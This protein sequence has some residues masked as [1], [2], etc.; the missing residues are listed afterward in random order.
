MA[1]P[2]QNLSVQAP[3][4]QGINSEDSPLSQD[5]TFCSRADNAVIDRLG[6]LGSRKGFRPFTSSV[7]TSLLT[8]PVGTVRNTIDIHSMANAE[9]LEPLFGVEVKFYDQ[10][11]VE[12][13]AILGTQYVLGTL[14]V[15]SGV[16][17]LFP[18]PFSNI[19]LVKGSFVSFKNASASSP[20]YY[21]FSEGNPALEVNPFFAVPTAVELN[22][23]PDFIAP[24]YYDGTQDVTISNDMNADVAV[25]AYGRLWV[26]GVNN[27]YQQIHYSSLENPYQWYDGRVTPTDTQNTGG[28]IDVSQYWPNGYDRIVGI[29]AHNNMLIV[30]GRNS[31]LMYGNPQ[32]DPAA[33]GGIFLQDAVE[34]MGLVS[35]DAVTSTGS[36]IMFVDDTGVRSLGRSIQEQSSPVGD[37]TLNVRTEIGELIQRT[38]NKSSIS[39]R[40]LPQEGFTVC[41]FADEDITY[42]LDSRRPSQ[43]GGARITTWSKVPWDRAMHVEQGD[44]TYTFLGGKKGNG[45][46]IYSGAQDVSPLVGSTSVGPFKFTYE[47]NPLSFGDSVRQKFPKRMDITVVSNTANTEA[48]AKWG[49]GGST[50]YEKTLD[51]IAQIPAYWG[52]AEYGSAEYGAAGDTVRRYR[53]NTKGSGALITLGV[54]ASID[55]GFF[56]MQELNIQ[57]LLGRIY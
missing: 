27:N 13:T 49:F 33:V 11:T 53:V 2:Q 57:T 38:T 7:D 21:V 1:Q 20:N 41:N 37:M 50:Q 4:F 3:A 54:E 18:A 29:V 15:T 19:E 30:F 8:E 16:L 48:K 24:G 32:G 25:G 44:D 22:S 12:D 36:D 40:Y 10:L 42:V 47:S 5:A 9:G 6:R 34:G 43:T 26:T 31:V 52:V 39:L 23:N 17:K 51:I 56:S 46:L 14:N 35:R 28:L 45:L 55:G